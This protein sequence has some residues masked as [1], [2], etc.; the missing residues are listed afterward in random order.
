MDGFAVLDKI[1]RLWSG[2]NYDL[3]IFVDFYLY[4]KMN[5]KELVYLLFQRK[6]L[7]GSPSPHLAAV[8][9]ENKHY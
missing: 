5:K 2:F 9:P 8:A 3:C 1:I 4:F 6:A 7:H